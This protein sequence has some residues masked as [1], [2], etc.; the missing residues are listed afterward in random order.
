MKNNNYKM[1]NKRYVDELQSEAF[2]Y[3]HKSGARIIHLKNDGE[4]KIFSVSFKTPPFDDTGVFHI[5]EHSVLAG[6]KKY[7]VKEPFNE[8]VKGSLYTFL[9]AMTFGDKTMYPVGSCNDKDFYNLMGVYLD[10][11]FCPTIYDQKESFLREAWH[12]SVSDKD[13]PI[14]INGIVYNEMKGAY[15]NPL[16]VLDNLTYRN[17]FPD[18]PYGFDSGGDPDFIPDLTYEKFIEV[19]KLYYHP[20]NSYIYFYGNMDIEKCFELLNEYLCKHNA[21]DFKDEIVIKK[22]AG[23]SEPKI[24]RGAY[25]VGQNAETKG[26][27]IL[28]AS[29]VVGDYSDHEK[30]YAFKLLWSILLS[31]PASP[32]KKYLLDNGFGQEIT[33]G[34]DSD[35]L[36]PVFII[37]AKNSDKD[38]YEFKQAVLQCLKNIADKGI[39][40]K[41]IDA[42]LNKTEFLYREEDYGYRPKGLVYNIMSMSSWLYGGDPFDKLRRLKTIDDIRTKV[43]QGRYFEGLINDFLI[44]NNHCV[45]SE[46]YAQKDLNTLADEK[47]KENLSKFKQSLSEGQLDELIKATAMFE[48]YLNKEDSA[49]DLK[50]IPFVEL[51]D[52]KKE[53]ESIDFCSDNSIGYEL[54]YS[55]FETNGIIYANMLFDTDKIPADKLYA[56]GLLTYLL[57]KMSTKKRDF[58]QLSNDINYY[59]GGFSIDFSENRSVLDFDSFKPKLV[60]KT[61]ILPKNIDIMFDITKEVINETIF[62]DKHMLRKLLAEMKSGMANMFLSSGNML[63]ANRAESYISRAAKYGDEV[64]GIGLYDKLCAL[65]QDFEAQVDKLI[66]DLYEVCRLVFNKPN[67]S[68]HL[69][70]EAGCVDSIKSRAKDFYNGALNDAVCATSGVSLEGGLRNEAFATSARIQYNAMCGSYWDKGY[71]YTGYLRLLSS[72]ISNSYFMDEIRLK[73]GAY[74]FKAILADNGF[75]RFSSYRDPNLSNTYDVYKKTSEFVQSLMPNDD[76]LRKYILGTINSVDRPLLPKEKGELALRNHLCGKTFDMIKNERQNILGAKA[77][78][79][80]DCGGMLEAALKGAGICTIGSA[81]KIESQGQIFGIVHSLDI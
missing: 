18:T 75:F 67:Y 53:S 20:A 44:N 9:N 42:C 80:R 32:L 35:V 45:Y 55:R 13:A 79:L 33:G 23:F 81:A 72:I 64:L 27:N 52:V 46:L 29:F 47:R 66:A 10:A 65:M 63:A 25:S 69:T 74:G 59:L 22:Q 36:Q 62:D 31:T 39:D 78:D 5:M 40:K 71:K 4:N 12:Y 60:V 50:K 17:L 7:P 21:N 41:L 11:V 26:K 43:M 2:V 19:H 70:C 30:Y 3:G 38:I 68:L 57:G 34:Y 73:G 51:S 58:S 77:K 49:E 54:S 6:S 61:K 16:R 1:L 28:S 76:E 14:T 37:I 56:V 24:C 48:A 15:S 8:L